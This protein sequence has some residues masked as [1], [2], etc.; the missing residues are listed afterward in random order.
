MCVSVSV[1]VCE[2]VSFGLRACAYGQWYCSDGSDCVDDAYLIICTE[3]VTFARQ[4]DYL[5]STCVDLRLTCSVV[6]REIWVIVICGEDRF[7]LPSL[8]HSTELEVIDRMNSVQAAVTGY[9]DKRRTLV[10]P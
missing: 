5:S 10:S 7:W 3:M 2:R 8:V 9:S 1:S 6:Q 4:I